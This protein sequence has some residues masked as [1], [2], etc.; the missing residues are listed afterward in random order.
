[1]NP[2]I[3]A[4]V[5]VKAD[6]RLFCMPYAGAGAS[7]YRRWSRSFPLSIQLCPVQLPG[8]EERLLE[9]SLTSIESVVAAIMKTLPAYLDRPYALFGHSMGAKIVF[10]LCRAI[11][12]AS[13]KLPELLLVSACK[14][15]HMPEPYP[16]HSL[17]QHEFLEGLERYSAD[18]S[19]LHEYPELL[20]LLLPSLRSDFLLDESYVYQE[21]EGEDVL[22]IP[23]EAFYGTDDTE[24]TFDE[25]SGWSA[26]TEQFSLTAVEGGHLFLRERKHEFLNLLSSKL[27]CLI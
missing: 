17:P 13:Y 23:I 22:S 16:I 8:R 21:E 26:Y 27:C 15:P 3:V 18:T 4:D 10:E 11:K 9:P 12:K 1:M 6:L 14:A 19:L 25:V 24:A 5:D 2:L 20:E 7:L